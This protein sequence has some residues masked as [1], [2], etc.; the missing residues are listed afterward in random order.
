MARRYRSI[1][2][3]AFGL[4][5]VA[6]AHPYLAALAEEKETATSPAKLDAKAVDTKAVDSKKLD[7]K[8]LTFFEKRIRPVLAEH[9][10]DCHGED[11]QEGG[12]RLDSRA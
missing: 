5:A 7:P 11:E 12:L 6:F 9:C 8:V 3:F 2:L 10:Y 1:A 4:A